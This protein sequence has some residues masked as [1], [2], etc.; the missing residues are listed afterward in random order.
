[1]DATAETRGVFR[2]PWRLEHP[3]AQQAL[4][5]KEGHE[6]ALGVTNPVNH[7]QGTEARATSRN[8]GV[9]KADE[10]QSGLGG[11]KATGH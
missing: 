10:L 9:M 7:Q 5:I 2:D 3:A 11:P 8:I 4:A 6:G 1:M